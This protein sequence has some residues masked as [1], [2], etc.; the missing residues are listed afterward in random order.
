MKLLD[1]KWAVVT[2]G[3]SGIGAAIVSRF[4]AA[5]AR[6]VVLDVDLGR[7]ELPLGWE[8]REVD[9]RDDAAMGEAF[10]AIGPSLD[11]LVTC[12]GIVPGWAGIAAID[13][14]GWDEVFAVNVR[15]TMLAFRHAAPRLRDG[16]SVVAIGSINSWRGDPNIASY[17]AS[18]H[19][20]LGIVRSAA[21]ELGA[22]NIRVN[23][24]GPGPVATEALLARM[25]TRQRE[26]GIAVDDALAAGA[27]QTM[28]GRMATVE[29]VAAA[30]L[31][32]ASD[33]SSATTGHLLPVDGGLGA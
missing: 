27:A 21:M 28:L 4:A 13:V 2:G 15:G 6:G 14:G 5:G 22:R 8:G 23:A 1:G 31:F 18:K 17:V 7:G 24:L 9:V 12:A 30:A 19:A 20:V 10:G 3:A 29:E 25:A 32:L 11:V 26:Q 16:G 33:L